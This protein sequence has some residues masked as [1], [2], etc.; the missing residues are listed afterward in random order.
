MAY[1]SKNHHYVPI[2]YLKNFVCDSGKSRVFSMNLKEEIHENKISKIC[3]ENNYN[4]PE[5]EHLQSRFERV[6]ASIL[7]NMIENPDP[8]DI[9]LNLKFLKFVG[10]MLGNN[11]KKRKSMAESIS[12]FELQ[13]EGLDSKH[14]ILID[15]DHRGRFDLSLAVAH[16][17]Y[18]EFRSWNFTR[19]GIRNAQK[20]FI[21][22]DDPVSIFNPENLLSSTYI[23]HEWKKPTIESFGD[24]VI[25]SGGEKG[26]EAEA[27]FPL[28]SVSFQ[29]DI[30]MIFPI[31]PTSCLIGFSDSNRYA[32][33]T[34]NTMRRDNISNDLINDLINTITFRYSHKAAYSPTKERLKE[35]MTRL[36]KVLPM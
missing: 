28:K 12:S 32:R 22:S 1:N 20:V 29:K 15:K 2:F 13:I 6:F 19:R 5:Q 26:I 34:E 25:T 18:Q 23:A 11:I 17:F 36:P 31:A 10:F 27:S 4:S 35:T 16:A 8:A 9:D 14:K 33:F 24:A 21:T 7:K 30:M 3:S